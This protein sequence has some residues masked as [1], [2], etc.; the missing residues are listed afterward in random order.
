MHPVYCLYCRA[1][2]EASDLFCKHCGRN[3]S[4]ASLVPPTTA[5]TANSLSVT[6]NPNSC[7]SCTTTNVQK[8]S[9]IYNAGVWSANSTGNFAGGVYTDGGHF[10]SIG[11]VTSSNSAGATN[12][13]RMLAPPL[14]PGHRISTALVLSICAAFAAWLCW[15]FSTSMPDPWLPRAMN[16]FLVIAGLLVLVAIWETI[17]LRSEYEEVISE[18]EQSM[19]KW[20]RLYYCSACDVVFDPQTGRC[21]PPGAVAK[22]IA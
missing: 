21:T 15:L 16:L 18:W 10:A 7:P 19:I 5:V 8:I 17:Q 22:L 9:G 12:L 3:Q 20:N 11:G 1:N 14:R 6:Q 2:L 4:P 13:A